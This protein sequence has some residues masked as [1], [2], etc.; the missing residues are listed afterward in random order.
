MQRSVVL[1][2]LT[3]LCAVSAHAVETLRVLAWPGYAD[4][5]WVAKFEQL[6]AARVEVTLVGSD[7]VLWQKIS[8]N[9]GADFDVVAANTVEVS[10]YVDHKLVQPL[11]LARLPNVQQ[12]LPRFKNAQ[13]IP[14][15]H[16]LGEVF[17]V[18]YTY[19]DMGLIYDRKQFAMPPD[20][21][22]VMWDPAWRGKVLAFD[23]SSHNFSL[24]SLALGGEPFRIAPAR[25]LEVVQHLIALRRNVLTFYSLPE[26]SVALF[27]QHKV[28]LLFANYGQQQFKALRDAGLDVGYAIPREGALAWLD[29]WAIAAGARQTALAH[30]WINF[31]ISAD[32]SR[33]LTR[34]Q[35][36]N[37]TL[38]ASANTLEPDKLWWLE[39][40]EDDARRSA[41]WVRILSG[42]RPEHFK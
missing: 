21:I 15:I 18:P 3:V 25:M 17:A 12:Q 14:G 32:I 23:G 28:A 39:P 1:L 35:G 13:N 41:L 11:N 16:R 27:K 42:D 34:R 2:V 4:A 8:A 7:E 24:A 26:E 5:D 29:C 6:F 31:M 37:N 20:S 10:R 30:A 19:A 9:Q 36:L 38:D 22:R 33:E 40:V